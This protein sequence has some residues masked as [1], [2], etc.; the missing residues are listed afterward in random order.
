MKVYIS[1]DMEG[2]AGVYSWAQEL[3]EN[4]R[5]QIVTAMRDQVNWLI[6]GIESSSR[7]DEIDEIV[8]A[9][10]HAKGDNLPYELTQRD[11]RL[12]LISGWPRRSYMMPAFSKEYSVVFL[13][14]YH[15]GKGC[16][17]AAMDHTYSGSSIH[18]IW[19]NGQ[20]VNEAILNAA[21]AG[22][23]GVPVGFVS[24]DAALAEQFKALGVLEH[25]SFV[26]TKQALSRYAMKSRPHGVVRKETVD[27]VRAVLDAD[28]NSLP[29]YTLSP[30]YTM[31]IEFVSTGQ[32]D[33]VLLMPGVRRINGRVLE[34]EHD[35]YGTLF[36]ALV[37]MLLLASHGEIKM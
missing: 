36:N 16:P 26:N 25:V 24:G 15:A 31:R 4:S 8:V 17:G 1:I 12:H 27:S 30:P 19:V 9:D 20:V 33:V 10:S 37:A 11:S 35:D 6:E 3:K 34:F 32:A 14:G 13:V 2:L 7:N 23:F 18:Q 21:Y 28:V 5:A 22:S 29:V